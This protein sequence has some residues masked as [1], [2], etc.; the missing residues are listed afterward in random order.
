MDHCDD[1]ATSNV[2]TKCSDGFGLNENNSCVECSFR[3]ESCLED[4][5]EC[6]ECEGGLEANDLGKCCATD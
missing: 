6:D 1:C 3:C 4:A 5:D 2:C